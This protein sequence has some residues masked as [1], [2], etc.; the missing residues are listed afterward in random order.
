[1]LFR[2]GI[3]V[4]NERIAAVFNYVKSNVKWNDFKG[5]SCNDGVKK[6]YKDKVG[7]TAEI[8]LMLTAMLR[9]AGF[10]ANPVLVSTRDNGIAF[11][12]SVDRYGFIPPLY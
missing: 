10:N 12:P 2:S 4:Q 9:F 7:N 1:M 3:S 5:Y 11:F 8:N 6:A